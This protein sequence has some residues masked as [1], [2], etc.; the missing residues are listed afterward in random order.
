MKK[1]LLLICIHLVVL[2]VNAQDTNSSTKITLKSGAVF[3][4]ELIVNNNELIMLKDKT[5]ARFQFSTSEVEK[6]ET[7]HSEITI[8][9][10]NKEIIDHST[11][12]FCGQI[13][14]S[15]GNASARKAFE[16]SLSPQVN[17]YFGNKK[18][19]GKDLFAGVGAGYLWIP[20]VNLSLVPVAIKV[21]TN[22]TKNRTSPFVGLESGYTFSANKN[23]GGG[24]FA[25]A[26]IGFNYRLTYKTALFGGLS[27]GV[28]AISGRLT[29]LTP[30]GVFIF[31]G[32]S[33]LNVLSLKAGFQF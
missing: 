3:V 25:R 32:N 7:V 33:T 24:L 23:F 2:T 4:G 9:T 20:A 31:D 22:T 26:T 10:Q 18:A 28:Y 13:E 17:L 6:V 5:G 8:S 14:L 11:D 1:L 19:F 21:Q 12:H 15:I 27:A 30:N 29:D 16:T